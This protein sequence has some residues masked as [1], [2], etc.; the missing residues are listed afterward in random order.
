M[1]L[2]VVS[3]HGA[4]WSMPKKKEKKKIKTLVCS[5]L[6]E[7]AIEMM[8]NSNGLMCCTCML[9][10]PIIMLYHHSPSSI[11]T[12]N[13]RNDDT[14][15][16]PNKGGKRRFLPNLNIIEQICTYVWMNLLFGRN[17]LICFNV[18]KTLFD[19][20]HRYLGFFRIVVCIC[21]L[22]KRFDFGCLFNDD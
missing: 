17:L 22:T 13:D 3:S 15:Y 18:F 20:F 5:K 2:S 21:R 11:R 10:I 7:A 4:Q 6:D 1:A 14:F 12:M 16:R 9:I 19:L 8:G